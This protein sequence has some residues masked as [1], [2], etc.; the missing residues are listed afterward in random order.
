[1]PGFYTSGSSVLISERYWPPVRTTY[2]FSNL[3]FPISTLCS[4]HSAFNFLFNALSSFS[5]SVTLS[6]KTAFSSTIRVILPQSLLQL[7]A[8]NASD[9]LANGGRLWPCRILLQYVKR[10]LGKDVNSV[11]SLFRRIESIKGEGVVRIGGSVLRRYRVVDCYGYG[12][13]G[14]FA[15][16]G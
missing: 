8:I 1:M 6:V 2:H 4:L 7:L 11:G 5:I 13:C 14:F 15:A 16:A 10:D 12:V 9:L 3:P